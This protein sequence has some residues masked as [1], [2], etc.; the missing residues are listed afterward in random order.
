MYRR[1]LDKG[2]LSNHRLW[3]VW[4]YCLMKA[5]HKKRQTIVGLQTVDLEPGQFVFGRTKASKDLKIKSSTIYRLIW[6]L[7]KSGNIEI[8]SN[9]KF[10]I[11][12]IVNWG[13][14]QEDKIEIGQQVNNKRTTSEHKQTL[15]NVK[16]KER[17]NIKKENNLPDW[18]NKESWSEYKQHRKDIKSPLT[19]LAETK[20]LKKLKYL[21]DGG[22]NQV[23]VID[24]SIENGWKG[25]FEVK[26]KNQGRVQPKEFKLEIPDNIATPEEQRENIAKLK[27]LLSGVGGGRK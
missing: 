25:L 23:E 11:I 21:L 17:N 1:A 8:E 20:A 9:N 5:S 14:Y 12:T 22:F 2:W 10:S 13:A 27:G 15:K 16:N 19:Q 6:S 4:S 7:K 26:G 18:L 3:A 24:Q